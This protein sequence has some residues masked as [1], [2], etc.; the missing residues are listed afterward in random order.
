MTAGET[1]ILPMR[2]AFLILIAL[3]LAACARPAPHAP[4]HEAQAIDLEAKTVALV[5]L[6]DEGHPH[7]FCS[8]V[9]VS[10]KSIV[11][12]S[13][14][15]ANRDVGDGLTYVVHDD[16]FAPSNLHELSGG[17]LARAAELVDVDED[18]DLALLRVPF[19]PPH[20]VAIVSMD[21]V[22]AGSFAQAMGHSMGLWWS[23]SSGD[24]AAVREREIGLDIVWI[25]ATTPISPGNSGGGLFDEGGRL[26]G[27]CSRA[28][29]GRAQG[30]NF[31][32]HGQYIDALVRRQGVTI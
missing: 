9:W 21:P 1:A 29:G 27:L 6:D 16:V 11:T 17:V 20:R 10:A 19:A 7:P 30:L 25:Q 14:C 8:G 28:Y 2:K 12:A 23:Y 32:V 31:F 15:V 24:V 4:T 5:R 22:H 13:H 26:I 3:I 18:H